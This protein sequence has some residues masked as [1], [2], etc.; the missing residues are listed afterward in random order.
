MTG[1]LLYTRADAMRSRDYVQSYLDEAARLGISL[2][3]IYREDLCVRIRDGAAELLHCGC[4]CG[5]ELPRPDFAVCRVMEP[6]LSAHIERM[7][8]P[9]F[10]SAEVSAICNHKGRTFQYLC[11]RGI[12]MSET[13]L[14]PAGGAADMRGLEFPVVAKPA[15][16]RSGSGVMMAKN[17]QEL[18]KCAEILS[19]RDWLI[20]R[21]AGR[22][23]RDLR[24]FVLGT[25]I[26]AA[27]LRK[28]DTDFRANVGLGGTAELY[29]LSAEE[30]VLVRR[31]IDCFSFGLVGVDFL[32]D[33]RGGLLLSEIEDVVGARSLYK[34]TDI[35]LTERYLRW[36]RQRLI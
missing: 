5:H 32:F 2:R 19:G 14:I 16:G 20:Q 11:G 1:W 35:N 26:L 27:V 33:G 7:G 4:Q 34:L 15:E 36:I 24:I 28:S 17:P 18:Q 29:S 13:V 31:V 22:P 21:M 3:L 9:V 12:P 6:A 10:N 25:E 8:I 30:K 23:G